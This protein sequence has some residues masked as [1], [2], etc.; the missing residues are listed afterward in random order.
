LDAKALNFLSKMRALFAD[1][2]TLNISYELKYRPHL[3]L[4][5]V[6]SHLLP[7][8][9][10]IGQM[11]F[12]EHSTPFFSTILDQNPAQILSAKFLMFYSHGVYAA[13]GD[14][15]NQLAPAIV[16][17]LCTE[18]ADAEPRQATFIHTTETVYRQVNE[19]IR[20]VRPL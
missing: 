4:A 2:F 18:R 5:P 11:M 6:L 16:R 19:G 3:N 10:G 8:F 20:E 1:N 14:D 15:L 9:S 12:H 13:A 7:I 17:W